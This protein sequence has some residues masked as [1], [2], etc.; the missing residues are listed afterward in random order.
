LATVCGVS[1]RP[2]RSFEPVDRP[3]DALRRSYLDSL[4][5]P[6]ELFVE[7]LVGG[8]STWQ[9]DDLAYVVVDG[10]EIVEFHCRH[11]ERSVVA[12][13]FDAAVA[14]SGAGSVL[15]KSFDAS[16]LALALSRPVVVRP[17]G[18]LFR[19][20]SHAGPLRTQAGDLRF[21]PGA[22]GDIDAIAALNDG[23]F[24]DR[25]EIEAY[26]GRQGLFVAIRRD[27]MVGCGIVT[28]VVAGRPD[29]DIGLWVAPEHRGR[30]YGA[31]IAAFLRDHVLAAGLRPIGGCDVSNVASHRA[32]LRAGFVSEHR[33]LDISFTDPRAWARPR[34]HR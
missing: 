16:L 24:D 5:E 32:L 18:H 17:I 30:G 9:L 26:A 29:I 1:W 33:L 19:R 11:H 6:Q 22:A 31:G 8:G 23:F 27:V 10:A 4:P 25:A 34:A 7:Q 13:A 21:R 20:V 3:P 15:C 28:R 14:A 2:E 12:A